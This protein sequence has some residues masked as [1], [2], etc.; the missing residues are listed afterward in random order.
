MQYTSNHPCIPGDPVFLLKKPTDKPEA[1]DT[2]SRDRPG[3]T[4]K[5]YLDVRKLLGRSSE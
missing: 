3:A 2:G 4:T 5:I 1:R